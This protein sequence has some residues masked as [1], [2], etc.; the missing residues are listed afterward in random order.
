[1]LLL[2]YY[3]IGRYQLANNFWSNIDSRKRRNL[4][5]S[6]FENRIN[7]TMPQNSLVTTFLMSNQIRSSFVVYYIC[8]KMNNLILNANELNADF[9]LFKR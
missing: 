4:N 9:V 8:A 5:S 3:A 2:Q 1:M 7:E 6:P